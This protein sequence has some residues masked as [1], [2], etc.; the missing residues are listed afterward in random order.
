MSLV[1]TTDSEKSLDGCKIGVLGK[2]G[3]GKSTATVLLAH[4]LVQSGYTVCVIDADSTNVG[5]HQAFGIEQSPKSLI[6]YF[7]GMIFGGG[8]VTCPVDDPTPLPGS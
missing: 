1:M 8:Q 7:G 5:L 4:A 2:G 3:A 6:E